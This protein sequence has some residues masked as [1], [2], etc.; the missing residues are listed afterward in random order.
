M[1]Q[2]PQLYYS[3]FNVPPPT[4]P[5]Q[6][7]NVAA[8][9]PPQFQQ[10]TPAPAPVRQIQLSARFP[11]PVQADIP[12][13]L[14]VDQRLEGQ[15]P[16]LRKPAR[17]GVERGRVRT[18]TEPDTV[19]AQLPQQAFR[20]NRLGA[21]P[22]R[23][24][25][26]IRREKP[27]PTRE[28][29]TAFQDQSFNKVQGVR[30]P[31][32][33]S[34]SSNVNPFL[35]GAKNPDALQDSNVSQAKPVRRPINGNR[36]RRPPLQ[37][38]LLAENQ[39][40]P[41]ISYER[42]EHKVV[43]T[44]DVFHTLPPVKP[45]HRLRVPFEEESLT[46]KQSPPSTTTPK[47][48]LELKHEES[49]G[50]VYPN[51]PIEEDDESEANKTHEAPKEA[52]ESSTKETNDQGKHE[53]EEEEETGTQDVAESSIE[54]DM[55]IHHD[56]EHRTD[57]PESELRQLQA[58]SAPAEPTESWVI[59]ASVQTSRSV[60]GA[61]F[62]PSGIV[63]QKVWN[64][65]LDGEA[66]EA[67]SV[68]GDQEEVE[69]LTP[70]SIPAHTS[71]KATAVIPSSTESIIDKLDRVQSELSSGIF[72]GGFRNTQLEVLTV[73][74]MPEK[75]I[76]PIETT[77]AQVITAASTLTTT[78]TAPTTTSK[79][80][81]TTTEQSG[82]EG[83]DESDESPSF[84]RRFSP[85][86][87]RTTTPKSAKKSSL[88]DNLQFDDLTGLLPAGFKP[89][90]KKPTTMSPKPDR[91]SEKTEE[92]KPTP[93]RK[94][95][96]GFKPKNRKKPEL[97]GPSGDENK[98]IFKDNVSAVLPPGYKPTL[99]NKSEENP[100]MSLTSLL[101]K[102][103]FEEP[104]SLLPPGYKPKSKPKP[105]LSL[106]QN[107]SETN[108]KPQ[109]ENKVSSLWASIKFEEPMGLLPPGFRPKENNESKEVNTKLPGGLLSKIQFEEP[110]GL[111]PPGYKPGTVAGAAAAP[112]GI[113]LDSL[114]PPG[115]KPPQPSPV[116]G[117]ESLL[118]KAKPA[119]VTGLLPPG[120]KLNTSSSTPKLNASG[121]ASGK[122]TEAPTASSTPAKIVLFPNGRPGTGTRKPFGRQTTDKPMSE[123]LPEAPK[124]QKGW[125]VRYV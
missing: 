121:S 94:H 120:F 36:V 117:I 12:P 83:S 11:T 113:S 109:S 10:Q 101:S 125:P 100:K 56:L 51:R 64:E 8:L 79:T 25:T 102:I 77:T 74:P 107:S 6:Q 118:T 57:A 55:D 66:G 62:L 75:E 54:G 84:V 18:T 85:A 95:S 34:Q 42:T 46:I 90:N 68:D 99:Q 89:R 53:Q 116:R 93:P 16:P 37:E 23:T 60:S 45:S 73:M 105:N 61:R 9:R 108:G 110:S 1:T 80:P 92:D 115:Y 112:P 30:R 24:R 21:N 65:T 111:L 3:P 44:T 124:I 96:S 63:S 67:G 43:T 17:A 49:H 58:A 5:Q 48:A 70:E 39:F 29:F 86:A 59:V 91:G 22:T 28:P 47:T 119:D 82:E 97:T 35:L 2:R 26:T 15:A 123:S 81:S 32:D 27:L 41:E 19:D 114:L 106:S 52:V 50:G 78:S 31:A 20:G 38:N 88:L 7:R 13:H 103:K 98:I 69:E 14:Q 40:L 87:K 104:A 76:I 122:P 72:S 71:S 4:A 33:T